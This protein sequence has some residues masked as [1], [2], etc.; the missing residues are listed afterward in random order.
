MHLRD[1][2]CS[3]WSILSR[4]DHV[5]AM[6][7]SAAPAAECPGARAGARS[8]IAIR[9]SWSTRLRIRFAAMPGATAITTRSSRVGCPAAVMRAARSLI[10]TSPD[11]EMRQGQSQPVGEGLRFWH[12]VQQAKCWSALLS[13]S[14]H[15]VSSSRRAHRSTMLLR[16]CRGVA[17]I[18]RG[19]LRVIVPCC[20]G[21]MAAAAITRATF[22][23][24]GSQRAF[25]LRASS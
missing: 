7:G 13:P 11:Y 23:S 15:R 25:R 6:V 24:S 19:V 16:L 4:C 10:G 3:H 9:N 22:Q 18:R 21:C 5:S 1:T 8:D 17:R 2:C 14:A 20:V 12:R